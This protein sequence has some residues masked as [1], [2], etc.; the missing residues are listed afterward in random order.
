MCAEAVHEIVVERDLGFQFLDAL[1]QAV[2]IVGEKDGICQPEVSL[3]NLC[4]I[5]AEKGFNRY[6]RNALILIV[7]T[8]VLGVLSH[9]RH[10]NLSQVLRIDLTESIL[11]KL[12]LRVPA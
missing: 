6:V 8:L 9:G 4:A 12:P 10:D 11:D 1:S 3:R 5:R 7:N 2:F